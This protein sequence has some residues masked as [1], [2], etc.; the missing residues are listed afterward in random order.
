[1]ALL[2]EDGAGALLIIKMQLLWIE[3]WQ[4]LGIK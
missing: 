4:Q 2:Q 3:M 1:M